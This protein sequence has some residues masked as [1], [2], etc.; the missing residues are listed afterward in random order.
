MHAYFERRYVAPNITVVAAGNF[1]WAPLVG[2]VEKHCGGWAAGPGRPAGHP[3][4]AGLG[5]FQVHD[6]ARR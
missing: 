5:A 1:D 2:L 4:D 3:R 6:Q